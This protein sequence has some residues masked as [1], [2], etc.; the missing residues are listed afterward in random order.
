[1]STPVI[2]QLLSN[3]D[4][5]G[6]ATTAG[7][8]SPIGTELDAFSGGL[9]KGA[10]DPAGQ[11]SCFNSDG[12]GYQSFTANL[13]D[14]TTTETWQ[15]TNAAGTAPGQFSWDNSLDNLRGVITGS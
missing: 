10:W 3:P 2:R 1:G 5:T 8:G 13:A 14:G 12:L 7:G 15:S 6:V 11:P 4:E 9:G